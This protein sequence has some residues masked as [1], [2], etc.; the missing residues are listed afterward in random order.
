MKSDSLR[1]NPKWIAWMACT[2]FM[3]FSPFAATAAGSVSEVQAVQQQQ[4]IKGIVVDATG[5]GVIGASVVVEG[6]TIGV[7]TDFDG[8][9]SLQVPKGGK[10]K[11]SFIGYKD[12]VITQ[13]SPGKEL[14][15]V[16]EDD[17]QMLG[18]VEV[19]AY[20]AQKKVTITGAISSM[21]GD[22]LLKTPAASLSN[23]LSGQVTGISSVQYSGEPGA[24]AA[25]LYVRGIATWNNAAPL[26]QVDGVERSM[27]DIDPNEIESVTVLKDASATAVFGIRGANGVILITT[28]RGKEGKANV[29]FNT[30]ASILQ[31]TKMV[32]QANAYE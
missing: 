18:E 29:T 6:T 1:Q 28:K 16:L 30:S 21:K 22:D 31:P 11:I 2:G 26:I 19:V 24:D 15:V 17:S 10:I 12:Q 3:A 4:T 9:F 23:V 25:D 32:E 27:S 7:I 20:G 14:H 8:R 13:Y 5:E